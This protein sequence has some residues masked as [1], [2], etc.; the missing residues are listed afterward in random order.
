[1]GRNAT[2]FVGI[3]SSVQVTGTPGKR[4]YTN[5][6]DFLLYMGVQVDL[7]SLNFSLYR[8]VDIVWH[9]IVFRYV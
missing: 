7:S 2:F 6:V 9:L 8:I 1:M 5:S 3:F 4:A